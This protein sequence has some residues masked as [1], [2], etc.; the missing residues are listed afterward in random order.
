MRW[1][2]YRPENVPPSVTFR[3][4]SSALRPG[5]DDPGPRGCVKP[6][7]VTTH[8]SGIGQMEVAGVNLGPSHRKQT[9]VL[10]GGWNPRPRWGLALCSS[11]DDDGVMNKKGKEV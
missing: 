11:G 4:F 6:P 3:S 8:T 1:V 5:G 10:Q 7:P 9:K 2:I